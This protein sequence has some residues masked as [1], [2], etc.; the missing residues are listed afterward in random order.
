MTATGGADTPLDRAHRAM[1]ARPDDAASRLGFYEVLAGAELLLLLDAPAE[2]GQAKPLV[3]QTEA[4]ALAFAFDREDRLASF[5]EAPSPYLA[6]SGRRLAEMLSARDLG[7]GL[8][9]GVAP[10]SILLPAE[11]MAWLHQ[12]TLQRP[13]EVAA[14][15]SAVRP[16]A[17]PP[18][19]LLAALD[20]KLATMAGLAEAAILADLSYADGREGTVLAILGA[21]QELTAAIAETLAETLHLNSAGQTI[22]ITFVDAGTSLA[23]RLTRVGIK[24]DLP[25]P[26]APPQRAPDQ[27]P[28]LR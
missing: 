15:P 13:E 22:D 26:E 4:G 5:A 28:R 18:P 9:V 20:R 10:S 2:D 1:E 14:S 21:P 16:P 11:A 23:E 12:A 17:D 7:L 3:L 19:G 25:A 6:L 8:N 24:I 27:P